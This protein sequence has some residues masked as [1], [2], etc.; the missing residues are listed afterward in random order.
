MKSI[1]AKLERQILIGMIVSD[2]FL[3]DVQPIYKSEY[4]NARASKLIAGWCSEYWQQYEKAPNKHIQ[5]I[6][7]SKVRE[8]LDSDTEDFIGDL[9]GDLSDESERVDKFNAE[10]LLDRTEKLFKERS[11]EALSEDIKTCLEKDNLEEAEQLIQKHTPV[12]QAT[13]ATLEKGFTAEELQ[14]IDI[15]E[16]DWIIEGVIPSGLTLF[17]GKPKT[18]KSFFIL[19]AAIDLAN[20]N[21]AFGDIPTITSQVLYLALEDP[22]TRLKDR[23]H[24]IISDEKWPDK[25]KIYP[26]GEWPK[27]HKGGLQALEEWMEQHPDT[28]LIIIDTLERFKKPQKST[29]YNYSEDYQTLSPLHEFADKYKVGVVVIHH[30]R[31][32]KA[33][34]IFDEI[35]S[36]GGLTGVADT[37][38]ILRRDTTGK[39]ERILSY[40]GRDVGEE[41][42]A[43][44]F[45]GFRWVLMG[46]ADKYKL[47]DSRQAIVNHLNSEREPVLRQELVE[48]LEGKVGKGIDTL[49]KKLVADGDIKKAGY[50][51]YAWKGYKV[52][53]ARVIRLMREDTFN[54]KH[55][56]EYIKRKNR[57][58]A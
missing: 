23:L 46:E 41:E 29:G 26:M 52:H 12:I 38:A 55:H 43:F 1:D 56:Q 17:A 20:G 48:R 39:A 5:D 2:Q 10:Y 3:R 9:L 28:K 30:T 8:G 53:E 31:K 13:G 4:L 37:L 34:D 33:A 44:K 57:K 36:T 27:I 49:L 40:R 32:T 50:G 18:G 47:S 25:L 14:N 15:P 35:Y 19:N 21:N 58:T 42:L 51:K 16:I 45:E 22:K 54:D 24:K 7:N 11:L 6:F